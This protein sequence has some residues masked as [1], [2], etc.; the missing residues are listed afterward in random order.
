MATEN[1]PLAYNEEKGVCT[2]FSVV[3]HPNLFILVGNE[4]MHK[5]TDEFDFRPD[6]PTDYYDYLRF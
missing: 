1:P 4:N 2:F 6:Q 3:F 5:I